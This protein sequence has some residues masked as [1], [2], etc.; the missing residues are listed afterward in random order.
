MV[1]EFVGLH[2]CRRF[3]IVNQTNKYYLTPLM[4]AQH[5]WIFPQTMIQALS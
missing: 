4:S 3:V 2:N 1:E 5:S